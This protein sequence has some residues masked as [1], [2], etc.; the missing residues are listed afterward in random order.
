MK[1]LLDTCVISEFARSR[2]NAS[3]ID[4]LCRQDAGT[5][6]ISYITVGELKK[7]IVKRGGDKRAQDLERWLNGDI[8]LRFSDRILPVDKA[9]S[10]E[11]GRICGE[12]E[13]IGHSRSAMDALI[14][15]TTRVHGMTLVTRNINDMVGMDVPLLNPFYQ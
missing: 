11:W 9:V 3:V 8:L 1:Y 13:R 10:L 2:P 14:A 15:A 6:Y 12:G 7:G 5:L 4:W